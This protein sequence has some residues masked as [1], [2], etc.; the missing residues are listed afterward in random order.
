VRAE[1]ER[2][3]ARCGGRLVGEAEAVGGL[4]DR[5]HGRPG[6]A[7]RGDRVRGR[8]REH[9]EVERE[10]AREL[11]VRLEPFRVDRV[12]PQAARAPGGLLR[13]ERLDDPAGALLLLRRG[14]VLEVGDDRVGGRRER[15]P[16]LPLLGGRREEERPDEREVHEWR[17]QE[18]SASR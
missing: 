10:P 17:A 16:E 18:S 1:R 4:D 9:Q 2:E 5:E 13:E 14:A 8:L 11:E 7:E 12:D 3:H 15:P 6:R